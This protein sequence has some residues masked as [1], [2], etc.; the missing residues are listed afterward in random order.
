MTGDLAE[1]RHIRNGL[2]IEF[3]SGELFDGRNA[4]RAHRLPTV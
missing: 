1:A 3:S 2:K 4:I